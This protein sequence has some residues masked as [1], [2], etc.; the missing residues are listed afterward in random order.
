MKKLFNHLLDSRRW[1]AICI[2]FAGHLSLFAQSG[3][4]PFD[5][6]HWDLT[7]ALLTENM[8]RQAM[9]GSAMFNVV[10]TN[11]NHTSIPRNRFKC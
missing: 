8:G 1:L 11:D 7:R 9:T 5:T 3:I 4:I 10:N 2:V 6:T